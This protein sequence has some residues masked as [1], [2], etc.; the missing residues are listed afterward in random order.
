MK[1][2]I[3]AAA[4]LIAAGAPVPASETLA[5]PYSA[6]IVRVIDGDT[7]EARVRLWLGLDQ[8]VRVRI[9]DMDAPEMHGHCPGEREAAM[10]ARDYLARLL[11]DGPVALSRISPDKYGGR[12]DAAIHLP[13]G[14]DVAAAMRAA[15]HARPWPR[16]KG[17]PACPPFPTAQ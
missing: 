7:V 15:G 13:T 6:V 5:G 14:Q 10:A 2:I 12:V 1:T 11:G 8:T 3:I 16:P 4:A 9:R 17:E